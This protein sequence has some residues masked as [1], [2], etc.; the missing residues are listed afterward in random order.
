MSST[1]PHPPTSS[2]L[3]SVVDNTALPH[4]GLSCPE[5]VGIFKLQ[6]RNQTIA[7]SD[8]GFPE[9]AAFVGEKQQATMSPFPDKHSS[10][11]KGGNR[12]GGVSLHAAL[13]TNKVGILLQKHCLY[14]DM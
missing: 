7:G 9:E 10:I 13:Q 14:G 5:M 1:Y 6:V 3:S 8:S 11:S 2:G 4:I 12:E